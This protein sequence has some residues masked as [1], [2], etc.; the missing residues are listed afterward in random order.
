MKL[1]ATQQQPVLT[2]N[3][4]TGEELI[5]DARLAHVLQGEKGEK[6]DPGQPGPAGPVGPRGERGESGLQGIPGVQG[7]TGEKGEKGERGDGLLIAGRFATLAALQA[8]Y[9]SGATGSF[10]V[11]ASAPYDYYYYD[12]RTATWNNS[13]PLKG[14]QGDPGPQGQQGPQG[15]AGPH[16][17]QGIQGPAGEKGDTG[18]AG[19]TGT[20]GPQGA[21]GDPGTT[22]HIDPATGRWFLGTQD[23]G[24]LASGFTD[25]P[26]DGNQ[27]ARQD[28]DWAQVQTGGG[29]SLVQDV[30]ATADFAYGDEV[31]LVATSGM[32]AFAYT[33]QSV[34]TA[35]PDY[36]TAIAVTPDGSTLVA[37]HAGSPYV[38][39]YKWNGTNYTK[40]TALTAPSSVAN[41]V[42]VS[43]DGSRIFLAYSNAAYVDWYLW[44][45]SAYVKQTQVALSS[46]TSSGAIAINSDGTVF[47]IGSTTT[48]GIRRYVWNGTAYTLAETLA[49]PGP[50]VSGLS[51][52]ADQSRVFA[53][54]TT[55]P[56]AAWY[57]WNGSGYDKQP[58]LA[59][60]AHVPTTFAASADGACIIV[61]NTTQASYYRWNGTGYASPIVFTTSVGGAPYQVV[62][63]PDGARVFLSQQGTPGV[64]WYLWN[65]RTYAKQPN[66]TA[67]PL[68]D[69]DTYIQ[70]RG[71]AI[72]SDA[73]R[74]F[75]VCD[76][77]PYLAW[78][79]T[80][81]LEDGMM[82]FPLSDVLIRGTEDVVFAK[83]LQATAP[84]DK[85]TLLKTN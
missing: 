34:P 19:A 17:P 65:G 14:A 72:T 26:A 56:Y 70:S 27:Y 47:L 71:I 53:F 9:P 23:T 55:S 76:G 48:A 37:T 73:T 69:G 2:V 57:R 85:S 83:M 46:F 82:A 1:Q 6:G 16:G 63:T 81:V 58:N 4:R 3:D 28:G 11:G 54:C 30:T 61:A 7:L 67:L 13:G 20:T 15:V 41:R 5:L 80:T 31:C 44:N 78:N 18:V 52:T 49:S 40:Q 22:P 24:V 62:I 42:A 38:S 68:R 43:D 39:W 21:T 84:G 51:L 35:L 79:K 33:R 25:A 10:E 66:L 32:A 74:L 12:L 45:G 59:V 77:S 60:P 8:T 50:N 29:R 64:S 36:G 75:N